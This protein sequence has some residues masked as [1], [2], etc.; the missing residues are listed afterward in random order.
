MATPKDFEPAVEK[1]IFFVANIKRLCSTF[2]CWHKPG[3]LSS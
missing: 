3:L 1:L 2:I